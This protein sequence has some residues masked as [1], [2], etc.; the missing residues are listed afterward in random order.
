MYAVD[1]S[2]FYMNCLLVFFMGNQPRIRMI[3]GIIKEY[4]DS[5][6]M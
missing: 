5:A 3:A 4:I 6:S 1:A 2:N